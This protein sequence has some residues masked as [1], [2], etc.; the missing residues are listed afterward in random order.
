MKVNQVL[1]AILVIGVLIFIYGMF[2]P[3]ISGIFTIFSGIGII[4]FAVI[5][6]GIYKF[7]FK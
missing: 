3:W 2:Q 5:A 6:M 4:F 7:F 1:F